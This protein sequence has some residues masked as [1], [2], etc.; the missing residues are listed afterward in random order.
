[1]FSITSESG[2]LGSAPL[3]RAALRSGGA[4]DDDDDE[5][6]YSVS[7]QKTTFSDD[8]SHLVERWMKISAASRDRNAADRITLT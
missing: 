1:M 4:D 8:R 6:V 2:R 7:V 5:S 3:P